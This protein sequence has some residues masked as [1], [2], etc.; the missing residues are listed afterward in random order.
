MANTLINLMDGW[1]LDG[2]SATNLQLTWLK[3]SRLQEVMLIPST[4]STYTL[5]QL[6]ITDSTKK[7]LTNKST[8]NGSQSFCQAITVLISC[9]HLV[10]TTQT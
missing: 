8:A 7:T 6:S 5:L 3:E 9:P 2:K 10:P 4:A 1:K